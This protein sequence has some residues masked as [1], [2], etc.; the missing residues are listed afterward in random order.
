MNI[1]RYPDHYEVVDNRDW[2]TVSYT[3]K[4]IKRLG[5]VNERFAPTGCSE[6]KYPMPLLLQNITRL[7]K[8]YRRGGVARTASVAEPNHSIT[9]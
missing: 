6:V 8:Q 7:L 2:F 3:M 9:Q 4:T 5:T 1:Y